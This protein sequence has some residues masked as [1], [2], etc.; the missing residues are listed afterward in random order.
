MFILNAQKNFFA[1]IISFHCPKSADF[2][3]IFLVAARNSDFIRISETLGQL[4]PT[5]LSSPEGMAIVVQTC[6]R[7]TKLQHF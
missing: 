4:I 6:V 2:A 5:P 1:Q 7:P 3:Q